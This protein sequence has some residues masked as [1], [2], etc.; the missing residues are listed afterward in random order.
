MQGI[1]KVTVDLHVELYDRS[2]RHLKE[3]SPLEGNMVTSG[4]NY[5]YDFDNP[6]PDDFRNRATILLARQLM[7][8]EG[9]RWIASDKDLFA[10]WLALLDEDHRGARNLGPILW[11]ADALCIQFCTRVSTTLTAH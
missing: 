10:I 2:H 4:A 9:F 11:R 7:P 5:K 6:F 3:W 1:G 8:E